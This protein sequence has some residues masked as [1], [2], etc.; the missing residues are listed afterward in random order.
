MTTDETGKQ[1]VYDAW[2]RLVTVKNSGGTTIATYAYDPL[3]RRVSETASSTT[4]NLYYSAQWQVVEERVSGAAT[5]SYVWSSVYVDAMVARDRDTDAN[6]SLDERLYVMHDANFNVTGLVNTSGTVVERYTYDPFGAATVHDGSWTVT[7]TAYVWQYLHQGGRLSVQSGLY[8]FRYREYSPTLGRWATLD[9]ILYK[10][11]TQ[12]FYLYS[13]NSPVLFIDPLGLTG[14]ANRTGVSCEQGWDEVNRSN[15]TIDDNLSI[16][17]NSRWLTKWIT[18]PKVVQFW[19]VFDPPQI[20]F[21]L[22]KAT[23]FSRYYWMKSGKS[24]NSATCKCPVET[25]TLTVGVSTEEGREIANSRSVTGGWAEFVSIELGYS[26]TL[27]ETRVKGTY[28]E[29]SETIKIEPGYEYRGIPLAE[30]LHQHY[31]L[32]ITPVTRAGKRYDHIYGTPFVVSA[33]T[34][35]QTGTAGMLI[36]KRKCR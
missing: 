29:V 9:P 13:I 3:T 35:V 30:V 17:P 34:D 26:I 6:G 28:L 19:N 20:R 33:D 36:C 2:N 8:S 25:V 7:S 10:S 16:W 23:L 24:A 27:S 21:W 1:F 15:H 4:T 14:K 31:E 32:N 22:D 18:N 5:K 11:N 12:N